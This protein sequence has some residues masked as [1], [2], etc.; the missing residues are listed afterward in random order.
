MLLSQEEAVEFAHAVAQVLAE[1]YDVDL[2]HIKGPALDPSLR[3][4][5]APGEATSLRQSVD[6]DVLVRPSHVARLSQ[7]LLD[8]GWRRH[9]DFADGSA[10]GHA[11]TWGNDRVGFLD[12]HRY[13][14]G[15]ELEA[16]AAFELLWRQRSRERVAGIACEVPSL[17]A[18]R[19]IMI[20]H[21]ARGTA[22]RRS[23]SDID[24]AWVHASEEGRR[25]IE[26]LADRL[27]TRVA[28]YAGTGR[29]DE[30]AGEPG[31]RLWRELNDPRREL[32]STWW[33]RVQ[34]EPGLVAKMR[35]GLHLALPNTTRM[36]TWL[37]RPPT[38]REVAAAYADRLWLGTRALR[39]RI[40]SR[41][42]R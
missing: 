17:T 6:A 16:E 3:A 7:A 15:I 33:A 36:E 11:A 35:K 40:V 24:V 31:Y 1:D 37:G 18:Q 14:P 2:L 27:Q 26:D 28:L 20:I 23:T 13:F 8:H 9:F 39:A 32:I 38:R 12:V 4:V 22:G 29:L 30:V 21:A 42:S 10:F 34:V 25:E 19:L 5:S 41:R